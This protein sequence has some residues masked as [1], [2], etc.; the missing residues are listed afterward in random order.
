MTMGKSIS[1]IGH[2]RMK[3]HRVGPKAQQNPVQVLGWRARRAR[4]F[5]ESN[6][7]ATLSFMKI[8]TY[9]IVASTDWL[10]LSWFSSLY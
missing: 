9:E 5:L 2:Y 3:A 4:T 6:T 1:Y 7:T 8:E 10:H